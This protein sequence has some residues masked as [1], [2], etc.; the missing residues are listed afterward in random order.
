MRISLQVRATTSPGSEAPV[1]IVF[2]QCKAAHTKQAVQGASSMFHQVS[3]SMAV[4]TGDTTH[5]HLHLQNTVFISFQ[6]G[7][8]N[9]ELV[10]DLVGEDK[11]LGGLTAQGANVEVNI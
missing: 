10:Q 7:L 9:E 4:M 6:N 2:V 5:L 3:Q 1:D 8:G 11:V